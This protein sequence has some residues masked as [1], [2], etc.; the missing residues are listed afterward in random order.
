[1][2]KQLKLLYLTEESWPTSR[3][4]VAVLFGK[5]LPRC[6]ISTDLVALRN[7][8]VEVQSSDQFWPGGHA[9]L[10]DAPRNPML[11]HLVKTWR[12]VRFILQ[13]E[14]GKYQALQV[15]DMPVIGVIAMLVTR[16]KGIPFYYWMSFPYPEGQI[17]RAKARGPGAGLR[18][19]VPL[20]QGLVGK[21][22]LYR[23]LLP[24]SRHVFVQSDQMRERVATHGIARECMTPVPMGVD[25][26][27]AQ[28]EQITPF[29]DPRLRGKRIVIYLGVLERTRK[30]EALFEMLTFALKQQPEILLVL[31]GDTKDSDHL[32]WLKAEAVRMGVSHAVLWI[33][34]V[35][36][37]VAWQYVRAAQVGI[38]II[39]RGVLF[40][41]AS[42]TKVVEYLAL[43]IPVL[44]N[45]NP[46][47]EEIIRESACGICIPYSPEAFSEALVQ[48]LSDPAKRS[49]MVTKGR[50]YVMRHR[51]YQLLS[52]QLAYQYQRLLK[53]GSIC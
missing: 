44:A 13:C 47:Q 17:L 24:N 38:S 3:P 10:F 46:D 12:L 8:D 37:A 34:W 26:E 30:I 48:L 15:R 45:D 20:I 53:V 23:W 25:I 52:E 51:G 42:P 41:G 40:D 21:W 22:L 36:T 6:G 18:Y 31:V 28:F 33:G 39:P 7:T 32:A 43:G 49:E 2:N 5:Y 16:F 14:A 1:M 50:A 29:P 11:R 4:D 9:Y 35:P 19:F 27:A